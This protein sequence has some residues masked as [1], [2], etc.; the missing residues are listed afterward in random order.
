MTPTIVLK[1]GKLFL[2]LGSP[3]GGRIITTVAEILLSVV[4]WKMNSQEAVNAPRFHHQWLPD[5]LDLEDDL[6]SPDTVRLLRERGYTVSIGYESLG[7][8]YR[9]WSD[10]ECIAVDP[11]TGERLGASDA[12]N[13]GKP[14]GY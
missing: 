4:D 13:N 3:G 12:R 7:K 14:V 9:W 8:H 6:F 10:G 5:R 11:Q 1:D 2:V